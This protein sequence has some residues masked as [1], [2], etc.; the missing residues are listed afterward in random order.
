MCICAHTNDWVVTFL[1][2]M[3][4]DRHLHKIK[5]STCQQ[6][7]HA[8]TKRPWYDALAVNI[9]WKYDNDWS[10]TLDDEQS[11]VVYLGNKDKTSPELLAAHEAIQKQDLEWRG[12]KTIK[13]PKLSKDNAHLLALLKSSQPEFN[14]R[15]RRVNVKVRSTTNCNKRIEQFENRQVITLQLK[16]PPTIVTSIDSSNSSTNEKIAVSRRDVVKWLEAAN[17]REY[18]STRTERKEIT[19]AVASDL[20]FVEYDPSRNPGQCDMDDETE[21]FFGLFIHDHPPLQHHGKKNIT[22]P[23]PKPKTHSPKRTK[24]VQEQQND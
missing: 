5:C 13:A 16:T 14:Y 9:E 4:D 15:I 3:I 12:A 10:F 22:K 21:N 7:Y 2:T 8:E 1:V 17:A 19:L 23:L 11:L 24:T 6:V 18:S 20:Y